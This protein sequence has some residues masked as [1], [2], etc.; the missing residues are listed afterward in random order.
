MNKPEENREKGE[1]TY[2]VNES[3]KEFHWYTLLSIDNLEDTCYHTVL[4]FIIYLRITNDVYQ[5][6]GFENFGGIRLLYNSSIVFLPLTVSLKTLQEKS[7][8]IKIGEEK[9]TVESRH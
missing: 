5:F 3:T 8:V 2:L 4:Q 7:N 9:N 6:Y 1:M